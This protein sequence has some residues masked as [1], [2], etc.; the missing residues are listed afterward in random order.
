MGTG[1]IA[2]IK[3]FGPALARIAASYERNSALRDELLQEIF[4]AI[5]AIIAALPRLADPDKLKP[6]IFRIAHNRCLSHVTK[7]MRERD[8]EQ[9][10]DELVEV[11]DSHERALL[12]HERGARLLEAVQQLSL[13]YRQVITLLLE[14]LTYEEIAETLGISVSNVGVRVNRAKQQLKAVLDHE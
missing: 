9:H 10:L 1:A 13:P 5:I 3:K 11:S 4:I 14:E 2:V 8:G 12:E 7:Q 6:F